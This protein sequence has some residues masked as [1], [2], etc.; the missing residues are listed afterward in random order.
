MRF[1]QGGEWTTITGQAI[2]STPDYRQLSPEHKE[3]G[4]HMTPAIA[5]QRTATAHLVSSQHEAEGKP[6]VATPH[7]GDANRVRQSLE[8]TLL[9]TQRF[10][11]SGSQAAV[12]FQ[13]R[14]G[15]GVITMSLTKVSYDGRSVSADTVRARKERRPQ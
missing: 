14:R 11:S 9:N 3:N 13:R 8:H 4:T 10:T 5:A 2:I 1:S 6:E 7:D 12:G 15:G